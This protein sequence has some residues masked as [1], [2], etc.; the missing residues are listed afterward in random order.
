[1]YSISPGL[2]DAYPKM[3]ELLCDI[4]TAAC[5]LDSMIGTRDLRVEAR[6]HHAECRYFGWAY[7][8]QTKTEGKRI[9]RHADGLVRLYIGRG[10]NSEDVIRLYAH[11][12]RHIGQFH[13]GR[14]RH[15][16]LTLD[17]MTVTLSEDDAEAFEDSVLTYLSLN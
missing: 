8:F 14:A 9:T 6:L 12:L 4:K 16:Y 3:D 10:C 5:T 1:M 11:E 2:M 7:P 13:I 15:G 17:P